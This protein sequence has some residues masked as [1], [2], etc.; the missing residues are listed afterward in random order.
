M[1]DS[2]DQ[3]LTALKEAVQELAV[4]VRNSPPV[5]TIVLFAS[6]AAALPGYRLCNGDAIDLSTPAGDP[7]R[8][9]F[10]VIGTTYGDA[11]PNTF[12]LPDLRGEFLRVLDQGRGI[13]VGRRVGRPQ[14]AGTALPTNPFATDTADAHTHQ[15]DADGDHNHGGPWV[16]GRGGSHPRGDEHG[17]PDDARQ[18]GG[19]GNHVH[20][21]QPDGRHAH[22]ILGGDQETRPRNVALVAFI[23]H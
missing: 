10:A 21:L 11:G 7:Y 5:G 9:L 19:S 15:V 16:G 23:R 22:R 4:Q 20:A 8:G 14:P 2:G 1:G 18:L 3:D 6:D 12:R 13:D 17:C